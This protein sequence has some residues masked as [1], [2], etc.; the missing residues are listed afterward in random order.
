MKELDEQTKQWLDELKEKLEDPDSDL[1]KACD[2][3]DRAKARPT[4]STLHE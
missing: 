1:S 2:T 4:R 3:L